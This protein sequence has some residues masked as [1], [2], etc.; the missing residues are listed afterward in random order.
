MIEEKKQELEEEVGTF[1]IKQK[2]EPNKDDV[3]VVIMLE[4]NPNFKGFINPM[5]C[6]FVEN[7]LG[8]G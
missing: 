4:K 8:N 5:N 2:N 3:L 7:K 6:Q 1:A